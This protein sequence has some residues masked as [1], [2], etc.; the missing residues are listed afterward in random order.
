M[1]IPRTCYFSEFNYIDELA[2][3]VYSWL[4]KSAKRHGEIKILMDLFQIDKLQVLQIPQIRWLS[5]G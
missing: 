1:C 2:N 4:G 3:K 5:R